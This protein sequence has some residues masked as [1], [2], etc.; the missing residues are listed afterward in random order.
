[1]GLVCLGLRAVHEGALKSLWINSIL[2]RKPALWIGPCSLDRALWIEWILTLAPK[3]RGT[4]SISW[5]ALLG[6]SAQKV[7]G[8]QAVGD[9]E[10][11][12]LGDCTE[13]ADGVPLPHR[14]W[15]LHL[16][17]VPH[18]WLSSLI[19]SFIHLTAHNEHPHV[20]A[21]WTCVPWA[22][23]SRPKLCFWNKM[24]SRR[25]TRANFR[26]DQL[27]RSSAVFSLCKELCHWTCADSPGSA[28]VYEMA[29]LRLLLCFNM[30]LCSSLPVLPDR[31]AAGNTRAFICYLQGEV[32]G[33]DEVPCRWRCFSVL[34]PAAQSRRFL[35]ITAQSHSTLALGVNRNPVSIPLYLPQ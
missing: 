5:S 4:H 3:L 14:K 2:W 30:S 35:R 26:A 13:R 9:R 11:G 20:A 28:S 7:S 25:R 32:V 33:C 16:T 29:G 6:H 31:W 23:F 18:K 1:M 12:G 15:F 17:S 34:G 27:G 21:R 19:S 8:T 10:H 22:H 24:N